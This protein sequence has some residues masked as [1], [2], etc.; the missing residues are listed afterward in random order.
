MRMVVILSL[1]YFCW[2]SVQRIRD[3]FF[4]LIHKRQIISNTKFGP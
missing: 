2:R 1:V 3:I 4:F